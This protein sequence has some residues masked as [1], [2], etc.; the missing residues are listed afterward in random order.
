MSASIQQ[1][2]TRLH[3]WSR[4]IGEEWD[5]H[6]LF[7]LAQPPVHYKRQGINIECKNILEI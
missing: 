5:N 4:H 6:Q 1:T 2:T 7:G 3:N